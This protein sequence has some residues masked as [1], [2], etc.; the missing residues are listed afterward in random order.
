M[1]KQIKGWLKKLLATIYKLLPKS[2]VAPSLDNASKKSTKSYAYLVDIKNL[3]VRRYNLFNKKEFKSYIKDY[4]SGKWFRTTKSIY[5]RHKKGLMS[6]MSFVPSEY[7][8]RSGN[9]RIA[10]VVY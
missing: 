2:F 10:N 7:P 9:F 4:K 6:H 1:F 5:L 8:K 3:K